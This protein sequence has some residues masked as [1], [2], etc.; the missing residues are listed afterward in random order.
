MTSLEASSDPTFF[1]E[2]SVMECKLKRDHP[3]YTQV[4]GQLELNGVILLCILERGFTL[5]DFLP[6]DATYW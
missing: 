6:V 3:Y 4:Q 5:R 2:K 1:M